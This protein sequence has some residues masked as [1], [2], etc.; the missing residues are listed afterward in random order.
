[1]SSSLSTSLHSQ[2]AFYQWAEDNFL[3]GASAETTESGPII[4]KMHELERE[5][6]QLYLNSET[7]NQAK[8]FAAVLKKMVEA[9]AD[10]GE[11]LIAAEPC[12]CGHC[13]SSHISVGLNNKVIALKKVCTESEELNELNASMKK[14]IIQYAILDEDIAKRW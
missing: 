9:I 3:Y 8:A 2:Q 11:L 10:V 12:R 6:H 14:C 7:E 1:M 5:M 4:R 13:N